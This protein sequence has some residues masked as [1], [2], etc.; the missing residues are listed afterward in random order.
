ME[1]PITFMEIRKVLERVKLGF[2][3]SDVLGPSSRDMVISKKRNIA[4]AKKD[5]P[6]KLYFWDSLFI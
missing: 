1:P 5:C 2:V 4:I 6:L 3:V